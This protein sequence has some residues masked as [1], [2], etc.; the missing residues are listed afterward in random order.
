M[1]SYPRG[2]GASVICYLLLLFQICASCVCRM[3]RIIMMD[4]ADGDGG[5]RD[6]IYLL[7]AITYIMV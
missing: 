4:G 6:D 1:E 3:M 2:L 5:G 7:L